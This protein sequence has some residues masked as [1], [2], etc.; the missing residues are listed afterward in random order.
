[1]LTFPS[2]SCLIRFLTAHISMHSITFPGTEVRLTDGAIILWIHL[3]AL[4]VDGDNI[5]VFWDFAWSPDISG[6]FCVE[7][8]VL[9]PRQVPPLWQRHGA[10]PC[11]LWTC[12]LGAQPSVGA[13]AQDA[14][15]FQS[16]FAHPACHAAG[17][18]CSTGIF[19]SPAGA[20]GS[21]RLSS[22]SPALSLC[23]RL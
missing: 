12:K 7:P 11:R 6:A 3:Y 18:P 21:T 16:L 4:L 9:I 10:L 5:L 17:C 13:V 19:K 23:S 8:L 15:A 2:Y 14:V 20:S 1:M 22:A